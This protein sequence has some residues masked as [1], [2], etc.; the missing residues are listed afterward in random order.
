[1]A[2]ILGAKPDHELADMRGSADCSRIAYLPL[3]FAVIRRWQ[4][5]FPALVNL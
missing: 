3:R 4:A 2:G 1:V 5:T